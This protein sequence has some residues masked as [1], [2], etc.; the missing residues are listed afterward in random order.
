MKCLHCD[1]ELEEFIVTNEDSMYTHECIGCGVDY[2]SDHIKLMKALEAISE[3]YN[4]PKT[5]NL[6]ALSAIVSIAERAL[7]GE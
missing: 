3:I 6:V 7:E 2:D 5:G 1:L 4:H